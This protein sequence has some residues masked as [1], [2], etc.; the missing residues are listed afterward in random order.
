[1]GIKGLSKLIQ[2]K[3][4]DSIKEQQIK[5]YFGRKV[6]IDASMALYQFL[7]AVRQAGPNGQLTNDMGEVTSHLIGIFYRTI[8]MME[9]GI[10]PLYVFD[11]KPPEFKAEELK[12]RKEAREKAKKEMNEAKEA[13][14]TE[15]QTKMERRLVRV[16]KEH[17]DEAKRLLDCLGIPYIQA[18]G[19]AEAQCANLCKNGIVFGTATEDMDALTFNTP[20][21]LRKMTYSAARKEPILEFNLEK[22]LDGL[23]LNMSEFI[24]MCILCGC[25]YVPS[26]RGI[27]P[28]KAFQMITKHKTIEKVIENLDKKK[29]TVPDGFHYQK[30]RELFLKPDITDLQ[31]ENCKIEWKLPDEQKTLQF[32]VT[33]KGFSEDRV[34]S[35]LKRLKD[36]KHKGN[37]RRLDSFFKVLP[38]TG[39]KKKKIATKNIKKK[40]TKKKKN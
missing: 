14:D 28:K 36:S 21:L 5:A 16:N 11:G 13:G 18:P 20:I 38:S 17:T 23:K 35:G 6:A 12:K 8:R 7:I 37:Q 15:M 2:E 40:S 29:Y 27:G 25:D 10:K 30:A 3:A 33:E 26:I 34:K 9:N 22:I 32:L 4:P 19:E 24:D 1:M 31:K 39:K